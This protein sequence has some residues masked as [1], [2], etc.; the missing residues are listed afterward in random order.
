MLVYDWLNRAEKQMADKCC[1][2]YGAE[3]LTFGTVIQR[4]DE[5]ALRLAATIKQGD[6]V[7]VQKVN[8]VEQL[9]YFFAVI[10][11]GGSCLLLDAAVPGAI[12]QD[13]VRRQ[14]IALWIDL[15]YAPPEARAA[16]LPNVR[17][18]DCFL[19]ALSSGS[20]GTPKVIWRDHTSWTSAFSAQSEVFGVSG[21]D[22]LFLAGSLVYTANLNACLHHLSFGGTV[23]IGAGG[24]PRTW[25]KEIAV[26][27][28]SVLCLVPAHYNLLL[29]TWTT[30]LVAVKTLVAAGAK[31]TPD[32]VRSLARVFPQ[33]ELVSYYGASELGHVSYA[34]GR[35]LLEKP[36]SA[37]KPFP[38]VK[39]TIKDDEIW[40]QSPYLA[41][42]FR[43][44]ATAGD[45]GYL[46]DAGYLYV[47]GR[48]NGLIN[49]GG[50][51]V[52]PEQVEAVLNQCPGV[53]QAAVGG[54]TDADRGERVCAWI[55]RAGAHVTAAEVLAFCRDKLRPHTWP[56]RIVFVEALPL[57]A[58][59]K[60]D[61][62]R[63]RVGN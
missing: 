28:A 52:I 58:N 14:T 31:M 51:K 46:D 29:K 57:T 47:L 32:T 8:P 15:D 44:A 9:L 30:P 59:G 39:I 61:R 34:T 6:R 38:G 36:D 33:A 5:L 25:E 49:S 20:T 12:A 7:L 22:T 45:L 27:Q 55:L 62:L 41:P 16:C 26:H 3:R 2:V 54:V 37:G 17:P 23:V 19:G 21:G 48:K 13:L 56:Q 60:I 35:E 18:T 4:V 40:V 43:P 24:R 10:K 53:A 42:D 1:L 63:L 11:A 50:V